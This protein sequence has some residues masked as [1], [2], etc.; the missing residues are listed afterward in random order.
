[1]IAATAT[2]TT[3]AYDRIVHCARCDRPHK[4][5]SMYDAYCHNKRVLVCARC[6]IQL[7][8]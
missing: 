2:T 7:D 8:Y 3:T 5:G 1:M 4:I 6:A